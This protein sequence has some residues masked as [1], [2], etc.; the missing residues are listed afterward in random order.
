MASDACPSTAI[1]A[2]HA[3]VPCLLSQYTVLDVIDTLTTVERSS[4][5]A[6]LGRLT[7]KQDVEIKQA[8]MTFRGF[9]SIVEHRWAAK[10]FA[11]DYCQMRDN[12][13]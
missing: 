4:F 1:T 8:T 9:R 10:Q 11:A 5:H 3:H 12:V 2:Q 13:T 6:R 7:A